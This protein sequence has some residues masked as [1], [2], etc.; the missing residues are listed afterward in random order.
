MIIRDKKVLLVH[1]AKHGLR[2]EPPGGKRHEGEG[3]EA[4]II[5]EVKEELGVSVSPVRL[6]GTFD[7]RSPEGDFSVRMF[8]CEITSGEPGVME[9]DKIPS[10]GWYS[11]SELEG[12]KE[13]GSLVPN[14]AEALPLLKKLM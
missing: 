6:F 7:T 13:D 11:F 9:P 12:L 3:A 8:I 10:F 4:S 14:M 5:R 1:N 2:V